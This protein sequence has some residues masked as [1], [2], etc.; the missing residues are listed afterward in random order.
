MKIL[1][2]FILITFFFSCKKSK[3]KEFMKDELMSTFYID[4][5]KKILPDTFDIVKKLIKLDK[6]LASKK[7]ILNDSLLRDTNYYKDNFIIQI[8]CNIKKDIQLIKKDTTVYFTNYISGDNKRRIVVYRD[9]KRNIGLEKFVYEYVVKTF[10][11]FKKN[12]GYIYLDY[13][14]YDNY[15]YVK[16]YYVFDNI[17]FLEKIY[18]IQNNKILYLNLMPSLGLEKNFQTPEEHFQFE[19]EVMLDELPD[20]IITDSV[21]E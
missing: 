4:D 19:R 18:I 5:K 6:Q 14:Q 1:I 11:S 12:S 15:Y 2:F 7:Q 10:G 3:N 8:Y 16:Y 21:E 20:D 17:A 13:F 9:H